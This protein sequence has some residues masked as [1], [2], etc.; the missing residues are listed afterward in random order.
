M[1][2]TITLLSSDESG[3]IVVSSTATHYSITNHS[4]L[5]PLHPPTGAH[6]EPLK[7]L[8]PGLDIMIDCIFATQQLNGNDGQA[9]SL[10]STHVG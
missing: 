8:H 7:P 4:M 2:A 9:V 5:W 3:F 6:H 1:A 10:P